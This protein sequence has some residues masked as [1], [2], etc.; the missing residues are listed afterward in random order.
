MHITNNKRLL[1]AA[2]LLGERESVADI[3]TDHALLPIYLVKNGL[4]KRVIASDIAKGPLAVA[5]SN[6]EKFGLSDYISLRLAKGLE[7][8]APEECD[9]VTVLGMGGETIAEIIDNAEWLRDEKYT[10]ILQPMSCDDRLREYLIKN[11]FVI[12][13]EV[14]VEDKGKFYTVM[15][16]TFSKE[17]ISYTPGFKYI[18]K[19]SED[20]N[21][22]ANEF[23]NRRI[24]SLK[25][26]AEEITGIKVKSQLLAE[27]TAALED[28]AKQ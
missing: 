12:K 26:C 20:Q 4:A 15:Q 11:G 28:I 7:G 25:K 17:K 21:P 2:R 22:A 19:L 10:L 16:V 18:G 9:A 27:I 24:K 3:G 5:K 23:I 1:E 14:G 8:V 6:I 13:R